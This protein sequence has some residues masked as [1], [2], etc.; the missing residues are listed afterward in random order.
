MS[1]LA[2]AKRDFE[3]GLIQ[4][5]MIQRVFESAVVE[6]TY[7]GKSVPEPLVDARTKKPRQFKT[8]DAAVRSIEEIGLSVSALRIV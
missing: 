2:Q 7:R 5:V 4:S 8:L 6:L 1:T 3:F